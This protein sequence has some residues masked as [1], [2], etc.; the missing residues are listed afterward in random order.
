MSVNLL[1]LD[2]GECHGDLSYH[3]K[4]PRH[5]T[6]KSMECEY[7]GTCYCDGRG[8]GG[9]VT[10]ILLNAECMEAEI[11]NFLYKAYQRTF[12]R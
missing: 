5:D 2:N 1:E 10:E 11:A 3:S 8:I 12:A 6:Q 4:E 9:A 7:I